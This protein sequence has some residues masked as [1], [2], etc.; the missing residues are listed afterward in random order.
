MKLVAILFFFV[1]L[2]GCAALGTNGVN[3]ISVEEEWEMGQQLE[4][5]IA[6]EL[7]VSQ[8]PG[9]TAMGEQIVAT[10]EMGHLPWRFYV[11]RDESVNAFNV[12]GGLV[13][14]NSGLIEQAGSEDEVAAVVAHEI[15]HGVA[16]HGTQR[17]TRQYGL[18][19]L[20]GLV[21]GQ[22]PGL[23][24]QIAT[25][26][27]AAGTIAQFSRAQEFEADELGVR[28]MAD[29]NHDPRGMVQLLQRLMELQER[30]PG[31]VQQFFATHPSPQD[32]IANVEE[33]IGE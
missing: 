1:G 5:Q 22:D 23:L 18:S 11:V 19:V 29:A 26:I 14:V 13:Y 12:P 17:L 32:R 3:L 10:T 6:E 30:D 7:D 8:D 15:G 20:A 21:L 9:L 16:R 28:H 24:Q 2:A 27:V 33:M 31:A 25:E 4:A